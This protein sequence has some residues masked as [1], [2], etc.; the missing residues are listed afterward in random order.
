VLVQGL[1]YRR[2]VGK[3]GEARFLRIGVLF[4]AAGLLGAAAVLYFRESLDLRSTGFTIALAV[5]TLAVTGFAF[6]TPSI[7]SL[8]SRVSDPERQ[9]EVLG[10]N[11]SAAAMARILG[12]VLGVSLF[13]LTPSH[14]LPYALGS[15]LLALVF[16]FT[17]RVSAR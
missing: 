4:M 10:I 3:V 17:L 9:G 8:I 15:L 6:V 11:Q 13:S 5:M 14:V 7:Q 1:I 2:L 12:P 16:L